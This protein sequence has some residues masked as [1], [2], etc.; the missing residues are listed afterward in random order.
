M[1]RGK[2]DKANTKGV[3][4][5]DMRANMDAFGKTKPLTVADFAPFEKAFGKDPLGTLGT[6]ARNDTKRRAGR[7]RF[8]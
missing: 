1:T 3:W 2:T 6:A 7:F 8:S 5:Y 4:V